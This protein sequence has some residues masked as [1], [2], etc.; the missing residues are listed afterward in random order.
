MIKSPMNANIMKKIK[1]NLRGYWM[2]PFYLKTHFFL[3]IVCLQSNLI[4]TFILVKNKVV[5]SFLDRI[6][7][8]IIYE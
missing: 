8:A 4:K 2:P 1:Y 3:Y 6:I 5:S 7:E